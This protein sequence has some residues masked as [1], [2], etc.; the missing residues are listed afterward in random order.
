MTKSKQ[1]WV[2]ESQLVT[3]WWEHHNCKVKD[4]QDLEDLIASIHSHHTKWVR[5]ERQRVVKND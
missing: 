3:D 1:E 4:V 5:E 2:E